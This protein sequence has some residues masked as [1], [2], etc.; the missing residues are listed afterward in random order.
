MSAVV[1]EHP[2]RHTLTEL[3]QLVC[4]ATALGVT[5][6]ISGASVIVAFPEPFPRSLRAP[7]VN[8]GIAAG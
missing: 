2:F 6:R 5:F 4:E 1:V 8:I 3:R 7:C